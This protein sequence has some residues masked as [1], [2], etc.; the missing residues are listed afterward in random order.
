MTPSI[1]MTGLG[2]RYGKQWALSDCTLD[3]PAGAVTALVGPNGA[4]K[5]TLVQMIVG[6]TSPTTS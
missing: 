6:L 3:L 2:K 1:Q 4:G 5:T